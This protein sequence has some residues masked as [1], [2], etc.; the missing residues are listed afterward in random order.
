MC[1]S[2]YEC[3]GGKRKRKELSLAKNSHWLLNSA[4][5]LNRLCN[6]IG[7]AILSTTMGL[8]RYKGPKVCV[9]VRARVCV[10]LLVCVCVCVCVCVFACMGVC[11]CVGLGAGKKRNCRWPKTFTESRFV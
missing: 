3:I 8:Q 10:C 1:M 2:E 6:L 9:S 7:G 4:G 5:Q 11:M